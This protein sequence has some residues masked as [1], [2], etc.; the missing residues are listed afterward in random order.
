MMTIHPLARNWSLLALRGVLSILFGLMALALP[1]LV[2]TVLAV[3]FG[4][5]VTLDGI[6]ALAAGVKAQ[7][8]HDRSWP[9]LL[10][11]VVN[12]L[13]GIVLLIQPALALL[14]LVYMIGF[15]AILNGGLMLVATAQLHRVHGEWL[16]VLG[17]IAS[18]MLGI[19]LVATPLLGAVLLTTWIGAYALIFG[20]VLVTLALRLRRYHEDWRNAAMSS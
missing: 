9:L 10:E 14:V 17:G 19:A 6:V 1:G 11:G 8:R 12:V 15:W 16:L 4:V 20:S 7:A 5:Y 2:A 3:M 18:I 13:L